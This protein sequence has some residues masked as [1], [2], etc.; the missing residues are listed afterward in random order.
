MRMTRW[1]VAVA[2]L[3]AVAFVTVGAAGGGSESTQPIREVARESSVQTVALK[4]ARSSIISLRLKTWQCQDTLGTQRTRAA[5][6]AW[7]LPRSVAYRQWVA[8]RWTALE[9]SCAKR[10]SFRLLPLTNDWQ[11]AVKIAQRVYPGTASW[12]LQIS[13]REGGWGEWV[14]YGGRHWTGVHIGNDFLGADTVG[15]W[16]Q[17]RF[18]TFDPYWRR[19]REDVA[20][21]GFIIPAFPD[22][23]GASVY[24]PWLDPLGQALTAGYMRF[25]GQDACHWCL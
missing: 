4:R 2:A 21:R 18:S 25:T 14:W 17:F 5:V 15:G 22:R 12:M 11:T 10:L 8:D 24:Q 20:R 7:A 13:D 9:R 3:A 19:A 16:M 23:G 6:S 1:I